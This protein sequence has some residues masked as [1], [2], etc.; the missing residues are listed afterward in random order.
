MY[1]STNSLE[2]MGSSRYKAD[3][4]KALDTAKLMIVVLTKVEYAFSQWVKYEWDS[5]Y[6]DYL[7][8]VR[9]EVTIADI[10]QA[11]QLDSIT[12]DDIYHVDSNICEQWFKVNPDIYVMAKDI[13]TKEVV[14]Y[15]NISPVTDECYEQIK[16]GEKFCK[17]F[18]MIK[19]RGS[20]HNSSLYGVSMI[21]PE[22]RV[23]SKKKNCMIII[24]K[25]PRSTIFI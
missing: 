3:I 11:I 23:S 12:Y 1:F 24:K 25:I 22:F 6:N 18:G 2:K 8:G 14:A 4:D 7:S 21:P 19:V 5:F 10:R 20:D 13:K 15:V 17:L 9:K 16:N